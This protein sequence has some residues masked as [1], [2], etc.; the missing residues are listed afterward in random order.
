MKH[1]PQETTQ[2]E[3]QDAM[4]GIH[5]GPQRCLPTIRITPNNAD[6]RIRDACEVIIR[7]WD[8]WEA[9]ASQEAQQ[10]PDPHPWFE[11]LMEQLGSAI[12]GMV[13]DPC[14]W[15]G[16]TGVVDSGGID[17]SGRWINVPCSECLP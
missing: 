8:E 11:S 17:E 1:D 15:C 2:E 12:T 13:C 16:G 3:W 14:H 4:D 10:G 5:V 7:M 6:S 9:E